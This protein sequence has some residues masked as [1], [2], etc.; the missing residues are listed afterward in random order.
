L[1]HFYKRRLSKLVKM[2]NSEEILEELIEYDKNPTATIPQSLENYL[3]QIAK[4]GYTRFPWFRIKTLFKVKLENVIADFSGVS[5]VENVPVMPNVEIFKYEEMKTR[6][7]E[8][9]E[10]YSGVPFT[11]QRI[12]EII[13]QPHDYY[14]RIDKFLR[15]LERVMLV[16]TI[17]DPNPIPGGL[18]SISNGFS[19]EF[20][21]I[22]VHDS[23]A[24]RLDEAGT[25]KLTVKSSEEESGIRRAGDSLESPAKRMRLSVE[26][27][28]GPCDSADQIPPPMQNG[29]PPGN[30]CLAAASL[31]SSPGTSDAAAAGSAA[32]SP[33]TSA[34]ATPFLPSTSG[35]GPS[36]SVPSTSGRSAV[37]AGPSVPSTSGE[38]AGRSSP[39]AGEQTADSSPSDDNMEIDV[40]CTSS[41][42]LE[43]NPESSPKQETR[44]AV[45]EE[46]DED[47][48]EGGSTNNEAE[49]N[50]DRAAGS[51]AADDTA[52]SPAPA[53]ARPTDS[54]SNSAGQPTTANIADETDSGEA[55]AG[56]LDT[57][58]GAED[59]ISTSGERGEGAKSVPR[60]AEEGI[61][62]SGESGR[63]D[64]A[65]PQQVETNSEAEASSQEKAEELPTEERMASEAQ[66][67]VVSSEATVE[68]RVEEMA[69]AADSSD[70]V[71]ARQQPCEAIEE[72][73]EAAS[74]SATE[75]AVTATTVAA[76]A[77]TNE[78]VAEASSE[79]APAI[80][81]AVPAAAEGSGEAVAAPGEEAI[82]AAVSEESGPAASGDNN[83]GEA[84]TAAA[85]EGGAAASEE[86][87]NEAV[88]CSAA[89]EEKNDSPDQSL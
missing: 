22:P 83:S 6:I 62:T 47:S 25:S 68:P 77:P 33:S 80:A 66:E 41:F 40:E 65:L 82:A 14:K 73:A 61:S 58:C 53:A 55:A 39:A 45:P 60:G 71:S 32:S 59:G 35:A 12:C 86:A 50:L 69:G 11:I 24:P 63:E 19:P 54:S 64:L 3:K 13:T 20:S 51:A 9:L 15:G 43:S 37:G 28:G 44:E 57:E 2:E 49:M 85:S 42:R 36:A 27:D 4:T 88:E 70:Q 7:F 79:G 74:V 5:P 1:I 26:E 84:M 48:N 56:A 75:E 18:A 29:S 17:I 81:E 76:T 23:L 89:A 38:G 87:A 10:S 8:Q 52:D 34:A 31:V 21:A 46:N 78:G 72:T 16:V 30:E 67:I